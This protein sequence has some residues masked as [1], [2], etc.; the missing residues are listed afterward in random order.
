VSWI[1]SGNIATQADQNW[2]IVGTGDFNGDGKP[3]VLWRN[4]ANGVN[5]VWY[6]NGVSWIGSGNIATQADQNWQIVGQ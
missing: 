2:K 6:L 5:R 1:G 3:D 4:S